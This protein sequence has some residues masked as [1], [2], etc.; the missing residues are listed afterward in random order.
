MTPTIRD[1]LKETFSEKEWD[2]INEH[3]RQYIRKAMQTYAAS[4]NR[5]GWTRVDS[6][7]PEESEWVLAY[8]Q[9]DREHFAMP[10]VAK[11]VDKDWYEYGENYHY[12]RTVTHW[13][14]L[15]NKPI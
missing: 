9:E 1:V 11:V 2:N 8:C 7:L 13:M 15:P 12:N 14:P 10:C 4:L 3:G 6:G 5:Q